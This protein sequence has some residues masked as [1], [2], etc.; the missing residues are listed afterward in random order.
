M[1]SEWLSQQKQAVRCPRCRYVVTHSS[2]VCSCSCS[3][4]Y[5]EKITKQLLQ[6]KDNTY[7]GDVCLHCGDIKNERLFGTPKES[8]QPFGYSL[9][10]F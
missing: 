8:I 7:I 1:D 6:P 5:K 3:Y 10:P 9:S 4:E 2:G